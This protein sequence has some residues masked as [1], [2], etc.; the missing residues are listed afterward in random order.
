MKGNTVY[1]RARNRLLDLLAD[2][3]PGSQLGPE[4]DLAAQLDVSRTTLRGVLRGMIADGI[5]TLDGTRRRL[6]RPPVQSDYF[7]EI[8]TETVGEIVER[9]FLHWVLKGDF[10]SGQLINCA[11]LAREFG[12][13]TTAIREYLTRFNH[14]GLLER[15]PNSAWVF[16]GLTEDFAREICE[17]REMFELRSAARFID[18]A[19]DAAQ[20]IE[21]AAIEAEHHHLLAE[22]DTRFGA[23]SQLDDRF[24]RLIHNASR[25]RFVLDF[26]GVISMIFHYHYEWNKTDEK[27]RNE[28]AIHEHLAYVAALR[29]RDPR[30][31]EQACALHLRSA[32]QTLLRSITPPR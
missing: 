4:T 8:Q 1:K 2:L 16:K 13:S 21:L 24:H 29:S 6:A 25:N 10:R 17:I 5:L 20:W 12:T 11:E 9:Q 32:R 3:P 18:L 28:V 27:Q 30:A 19:P 23:F 14:F 22:I 15:R 31:V 7:P 26:Y